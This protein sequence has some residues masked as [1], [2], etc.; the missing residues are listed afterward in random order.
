MSSYNINEL[1]KMNY[2]S[3]YGSNWITIDK[4]ISNSS[5]EFKLYPTGYATISTGRTYIALPVN[6]KL[7]E[8]D[9]IKYNIIN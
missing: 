6:T 2:N 7:T 5:N 4:N 3:K 8:T 9:K 1:H